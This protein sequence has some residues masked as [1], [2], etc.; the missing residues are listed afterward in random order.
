MRITGGTVRGRKLAALKGAGEIIRPTS[1]RVREALFNILGQKLVNSKILD[2]YAGTGALGIEA[3]SRGAELVV[4]VDQS[5]EAA[6]LIQANLQTCFPK[7]KASFLHQRL[8]TPH[9]RRLL[10]KK[11]SPKITFDV[12]F[13]DPPYRQGLA[14]HTLHMIADAHLLAPK[15]VIIVEEHRSVELPEHIGTLLQKDH[16]QYGETAIWIY[17]TT[18]EKRGNNT[19]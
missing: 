10:D 7:P 1:D 15:A 11:V 17:D 18:A 5:R 8:P 12:I 6:Q 2:L 9:I 16:R 4:F 14:E 19:T 13:M 3:L